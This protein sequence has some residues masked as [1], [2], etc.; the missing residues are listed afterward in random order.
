[1]IHFV[2]RV[3][4]ALGGGKVL[5]IIPGA[6]MTREATKQV[7]YGENIVVDSMHERKFKMY[8]ASDGFIAL[9]GGF[10]TLDELLEVLCVYKIHN[11]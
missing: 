6:L 1:M 4:I 9:P 8:Q 7:F 11:P 3:S 5:G 2:F 10:G